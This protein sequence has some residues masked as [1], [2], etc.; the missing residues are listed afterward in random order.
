[1]AASTQDF[2]WVVRRLWN[3]HRIWGTLWA[4]GRD[5]KTPPCNL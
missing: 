2:F 1:M 4:F 5:Q 3:Q